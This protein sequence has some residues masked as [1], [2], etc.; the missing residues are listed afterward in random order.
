MERKCGEGCRCRRHLVRF[1][2]TSPTPLPHVA[3]SPVGRVRKLSL[4]GMYFAMYNA[5]RQTAEDRMEN[6]CDAMPDGWYFYLAFTGCIVMHRFLSRSPGCCC[7]I[8]LR[9]RG[10]GNV[11]TCDLLGD[12]LLSTTSLRNN[13]F[14]FF[15]V[16]ERAFQRQGFK[17]AMVKGKRATNEQDIT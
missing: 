14:A 6:V 13:F 9:L 1:S 8:K 11:N 4:F 12:G 5:L 17:T 15:P 3:G 10:C 7:R 2:P 16:I